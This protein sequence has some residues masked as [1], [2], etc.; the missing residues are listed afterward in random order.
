MRSA[1]RVERSGRRVA[2]YG[3]TRKDICL[4]ESGV[5]TSIVDE[6]SSGDLGICE[7]KRIVVSGSMTRTLATQ[8]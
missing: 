4:V 2:F 7:E 3:D 1:P 8:Y 6:Q 5:T